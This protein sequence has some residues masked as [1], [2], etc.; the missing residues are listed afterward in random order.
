MEK[1][2]RE[3]ESRLVFDS[4]REIVIKLQSAEGVKAFKLRFPTDEEWERRARARRIVI[5]QL[6][7]GKSETII[8]DSAEFDAAFVAALSNGD[9]PEIDGY[10]ATNILERI[11][12]AEVDEV[13]TENGAFRIRLRV[14]G[15]VTTHVIAMPSARDMI[16]FRRAFAQVIDLPFNQQSLTINLAAAGELYQ[17]LCRE[18]EGYADTV[19]I[20]HQAAVVKAAI[21]ALEAGIGVAEPENF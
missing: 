9:D 21:D 14:A 12:E 4:A 5:K 1:E 15:G 11:S 2:K 16:K 19:P 18:R 13:E 17:R 6:G 10:E 8:P 20:I 3:I 7:R